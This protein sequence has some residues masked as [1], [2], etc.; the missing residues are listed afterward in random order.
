MCTYTV[1]SELFFVESG[2]FG[3]LDDLRVDLNLLLAFLFFWLRDVEHEL[4]FLFLGETEG[5]ALCLLSFFFLNVESLA[6]V[7]VSDVHHSVE[8][9]ELWDYLVKDSFRTVLVAGNKGVLQ[10]TVVHFLLHTVH[11]LELVT[12]QI[13]SSEKFD[14]VV[15]FDEFDDE[16][17]QG[18]VSLNNV[19]VVEEAI[20]VQFAQVFHHLVVSFLQRG[21]VELEARLVLPVFDVQNLQQMLDVVFLLE[22]LFSVGVR[23]GLEDF[24]NSSHVLDKFVVQSLLAELRE[25]VTLSDKG[26]EVLQVE[27]GFGEIRK[28]LS[29]LPLDVNQQRVDSL[30]MLDVLFVE[31]L[32]H[33]D[34]VFFPASEGLPGKRGV[35]VEALLN[36]HDNV[37]ELL[38]TVEMVL[39]GRVGHL[40]LVAVNLHDIRLQASE[41]HG[42]EVLLL[43]N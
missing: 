34:D 14:N 32:E 13:V 25:A 41:D 2:D 21:E 33:A 36:F 6:V 8:D 26:V 37:K 20:F 35:L 42:T 31:V 7:D 12:L 19:V 10:S 16:L 38:L 27:G 39:V 22:R 23:E 9:S 15:L 43:V 28:G 40:V 24:A 3:G 11:E 17:L 5:L 1:G 4:F 18:S 30:R 29:S